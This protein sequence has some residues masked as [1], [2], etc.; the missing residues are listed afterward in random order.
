MAT[1]VLTISIN[2]S[3]VYLSMNMIHN[4]QICLWN[5]AGSFVE[6]HQH[7][8]NRVGKTGEP[9]LLLNVDSG[10]KMNILFFELQ[11][12][13]ADSYDGLMGT[14]NGDIPTVG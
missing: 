3:F 7:T 8:A 9:V 12:F 14:C 13:V 4:A 11:N 5:V 2:N 6:T 10:G 1:L